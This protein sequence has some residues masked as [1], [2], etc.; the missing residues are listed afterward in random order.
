MKTRYRLIR[1]SLR[2]DKFY[3]V[4]KTT[5][6]RSSLGTASEDEARQIVE[7][8]NQAERQPALNLEIGRAYITASDP[9][10]AQRTWQDVMNQIQMQGRESSRSRYA[11]ALKSKAF[12]PL[13]SKKLFETTTEDFL[14]IV[15]DGKVSVVHFLRRIHNLALHLGWLPKPIL[16]PCLWP[17]P[18]PESR[19]GITFAEHQSILAAEKNPERNL[20]YQL[21][22]EIGAAQSDAAALTHDNIDWPTQTLTYFRM[23]T[24]EQAQMT[25]SKKLTAIL[26][27]LPTVGPLFPTITTT[28]ARARSAE[29]CRR[30]RLLG[31]KG[32]SLH[33][34]RYAWAER[35]KTA[36]YPER[37]AQ[38][39]L[40]H[41][42]KAV[43]RAYAKRAL[44]KIP[45][46]EEYERRMDAV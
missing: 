41:N 11:R 19:R 16:A 31:L 4:D 34:Y 5:G 28:N 27:Q 3:C 7:A 2:G 9:A 23:K 1:R 8:R 45:A 37:F 13:R 46:L 24:G 40:G 42:S 30:C 38:A 26:N 35:A 29:F 32:V 21:L 15:N 12:D 44:V 10:W 22:W 6:K 17:K 18:Q 25:I 33:S 43:H 14:A 39:A 20:Y 36:G